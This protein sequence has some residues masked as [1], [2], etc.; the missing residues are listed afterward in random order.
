M[1][2]FYATFEDD[3]LGIRTRD[4]IGTKTLM[5]GNDY[6]HGDS[7][8][9][10]SQ[11][12]L[13]EIL[14]ECTD[15]ERWQMTVKNVVD[16]YKLPFELSGPE[17]A[18]VNY[19]DFEKGKDLARLSPRLRDADA[20]LAVDRRVRPIVIDISTSRVGGNSNPRCSSEPARTARRD[21]TNGGER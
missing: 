17:Q 1:R 10:H 13:S 15:E 2:N 21:D 16:L 14:D 9:P 4:F 11:Q 19:L 8:F 7:V 6:P 3:P 5:W 12:V 18:K 20:C